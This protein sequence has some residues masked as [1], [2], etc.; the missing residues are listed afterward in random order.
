M[1]RKRSALPFHYLLAILIF[2]ISG[3][4]AWAAPCPLNPTDPSVTICTPANG[5]TV[6]SPVHVVAGT[7][8]SKPVT[9]MWVYVDNV[10]VYNVKTNQ[11]DTN[12]TIAGGSHT[13]LVKA[14]NSAGV[15]F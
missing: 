5:S 15:V 4:A 14:W 1:L 3:H 7:T 9:S 2:F 11:V 6:S 10:A 13:I 8:S 12:L